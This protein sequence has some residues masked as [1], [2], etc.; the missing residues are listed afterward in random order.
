MKDKNKAASLPTGK[1]YLVGAG[2]GDPGLLTVKGKELLS[3]A[4]VIIF[5]RLAS[6]RLLAF[7]SPEAE[8]IYVGK[9]I[10][11]HVANQDDINDIIV[12]KAKEGY[13]V[14]RLK[15][16]DPFIFGRGG[17]EAE[18][19][20]KHGIQFEIVPGVTSAIA[21]PAYAG[22]PLTHRSHT[23]SV[24]IVTGHRKF[25]IEEA[26]VD[27]EGLAKGVGTLVFLMGMSNL[28][29]IA[30]TLIK[31]GRSPETP[32]AV[33]RWGTTPFH[34][35]VTGTLEH[36]A[37]R[38]E[39]AGFKPPAV[40]VVGDVVS[41][42]EHINW[43]ENK[44]LLGKRILVTRSREQASDLIEI[45]EDRGAGCIECPTID[46]IPPTEPAGLDRAIDSISSFDWIVFSS[47]NA[48]RFFFD[49][50]FSKG[51]DIRLL[52]DIKIAAV[53]SSTAEELRSLY[54]NIDLIPDVF[55]AEGLIDSFS[56]LDM[57]GKRILVPR[58]K[59]ARQ[60]LIEGLEAMHANVTVVTAYETVLPPVRPEVIDILEVEPADVITFTSSSTVKNF[61][62]AMPEE[63][64]TKL[65]KTSLIASIGPIT[66]KTARNF[67]L[68]VHIEPKES[69]IPALAEAIEVYF[70]NS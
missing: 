68:D 39:E 33:I 5:D 25:E 19:L 47:A 29:N 55:R 26:D 61:F 14:V 44:P 1:V 23:A 50:I 32:V 2:P 56:K 65:T 48:V 13:S 11:K 18:I 64:R 45:L 36:I 49:R 17:E 35:T 66:S 24:A 34:K 28:S 51:K 42:R 60:T 62:K 63:I 70:Q 38:V 6:P 54:L 21:A 12:R 4:E 40:I 67:G 15:G 53:G 30:A 57:A 27:W 37:L 58:A 7:V 16:G 20:T 22:I 10:G 31:Y 59:V 69:T 52:G 3:K 46:V 43:F 8:R 41:V 9:R